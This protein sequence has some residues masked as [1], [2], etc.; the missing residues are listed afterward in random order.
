MQILNILIT[1]NF[2]KANVFKFLTVYQLTQY[3]EAFEVVCINGASNV[4]KNIN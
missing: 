3:T 2:G 4:C 1:C